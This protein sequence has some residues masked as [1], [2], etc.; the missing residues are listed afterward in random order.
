MQHVNWQR[1]YYI[2]S[3]IVFLGIIL[4]ATWSVLG[5]L[6]FALILLLLSMA[7]AFLLTPAVNAMEKSGAPRLL[8]TGLVYCILFIVLVALGYALSLSLINQVQY[9]STHLPAYV[10]DLPRTYAHIND[11]L[12]AHGIPQ[13]NIDT[14]INQLQQ[15]VQ[16]FANAVLSNLLGLLFLVSG[17]FINVLVVIVISFYLTLDGRRV[18]NNII[19][20]FPQRWLPHV[21]IFDDALNRVVG[22]YIRGQLSLAFIVGVLAGVGCWFL[23]LSHF[24]LI[25]GVL[26]FLFETIPMVGP[27]LASLPALAISLLL[28]DPVPRTIYIAIYFVI[29]QSIESNVLGPRIVGH[30]VGLH[31]VASILAL[32]IF[33]QVFGPLGALLATPIVAAFWVVIASF[34]RSAHGETPEQILA[35]KRAPWL[36]RS[37]WMKL[38]QQSSKQDQQEENQR[39]EPEGKEITRTA[40]EADTA[41]NGQREHEAAGEQEQE[42]VEK[43]PAS[44]EVK[45]PMDRRV[46][47]YAER[48]S[49]E[50][51]KSHDEE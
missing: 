8:A 35:N 22:N 49:G 44:L 23:G 26:A 17:A 10:Q 37:P 1:T 7:V 40:A 45:P 31:P 34:Y 33:V 25:I 21:M 29:L 50:S 38:R 47:A 36:Q 43:T 13:A 16:S 30:A 39:G 14:T 19:N 5:Y 42:G 28:P 51:Q 11:F 9:F 15:Q 32:I 18:R 4:W 12:V 3:S 20:L 2:L 27:A 6:G 41:R 48:S 24:A 46:R